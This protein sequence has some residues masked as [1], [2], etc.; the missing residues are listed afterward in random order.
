[1]ILH[2]KGSNMILGEARVAPTDS[3][4][5]RPDLVLF[6]LVLTT[7]YPTPSPPVAWNQGV[8]EFFASVLEKEELI[9]KYS[10]IRT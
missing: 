6:S 7:W 2:A 4:A 1:M 8:G 9:S 3:L 5:L 10:G